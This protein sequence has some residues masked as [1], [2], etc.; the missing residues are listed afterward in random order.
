M[1]IIKIIILILIFNVSAFC[2]WLENIPQKITQSDGRTIDCFASGDQF[3]HRLHDRDDYTIILNELNGDFYYAKK[4]NGELVPS[5]F[6]VGDIDPRTT[7]LVP[8]AMISKENYAINKD[9][10]EQ[11][12]SHRNNRDAPTSGLVN[13][14]NVFIRFADDPPFP[15]TRAY[16][17]E[18]FNAVDQPS[19]R[20]Y[21]FEVSYGA[22]TVDTYHYP[23]TMFGENNSYVDPY[24]RGYYSPNSST[25]PQGY[26]ND[27]ERTQREHSLLA[28]A[29]EA[30]QNSV[31]D[32]LD[33]DLDND[34]YV[35]AVSFSVYGNVD[36]WADLLWPHRWS[37]YTETAYIN[38]SQV[39]D[40][41]FELTESSY[42]TVGVLCHEFFHVLGA[43]DLYHYDGGNAPDAVG[44]WD[45]MESTSNPPQYMGAYMKWKYGD[46]FTS[47]PEITASGTYTLNPL[48]QPDNAVYKVASPNS[49]TEYFVLEYRVK[50]GIYESNTPGIRDG[51]LVYRINTEAGNGNAQGPPDEVYLYRPS[52]NLTQNG[53]F[54]EAPYSSN[55]NH[56][57]IND[58]TNPEPF[59]YNNGSGAPGGLNILNVGELGESITF[60]VSMGV[61]S[62]SLSPESISFEMAPDAFS[63]Q[64]VILTND[65]DAATTLMFDIIS[66]SLPFQNPSGGP[67]GGG[68]FWSSSD[69]EANLDYNWVDIEGIGTLV[70]FANNDNSPGSVDIGFNFPFFDSEY[71]QCLINPNGWIGFGSSVPND[72]DY[73]NDDLPNTGS[74]R[75][76]IMG[77]WDDLNPS[78]S[79]GNTSASGDVY[80]YRDP[81]NNY[82]VIWYDHVVRYQ[83][84]V[85][86]NYGE[87]DFQIVLYQDG[88]F[89]INYREMIG[90]VSSATIGFQNAS[91]S[92]GTTIAH[93]QN[94]IQSNQSIFTA[95]AST[96]S[97][98]TFGTPTGEMGGLI[99]GGQSFDISVMANTNGLSVGSYNATLTVLSDQ[100]PPESVPISLSVSGESTTLSLPFI[101]ISNSENGIVP[102]PVF[103]S[104]FFTDVADYY[105]HII[106]PNGESIPIIAQSGVTDSQ[107]IHV[108]NVLENYLTDIP[109]SAMGSNKSPVLNALS[110]SNAVLFV[111]N[112]PSES[113]SDE[114]VSLSEAG[115]IGQTVFA[116]EIFPEGVSEY[117]ASESR[118]ATYSAVLRYVHKYGIKNALPSMQSSVV[119]LMNDAINNN[120]FIP[121]SDL[122]EEQ[123]DQ[124]YLSLLLET[125]FGIWGHDPNNDQWAGEH[126]YGYINRESMS[127]GD[128][129][130]YNLI[131]GFFGENWSYTVALPVD[132]N[133]LFSMKHDPEMPYTNRSKYLKNIKI[134]GVNN[135]DIIGNMNQNRVLGNQG[136]NIFEGGGSSDF[137]DGGQGIDRAVFSGDQGEYALLFPAEWNDYKLIIVDF[138]DSRDGA[139]TLLNVEELDFNGTLY[140]SDG[141]LL[142]VE[143]N[144]NLPSR[145]ALFPNF[146]N[147]F[148]PETVIKFALPRHSSVSLN[149]VNVLGKTV[150]LLKN[151]NMNSGYHQ[152]KWDGLDDS[153]QLVSAGIYFINLKSE[154]YFSSRKILLLK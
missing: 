48:Q 36:G 68:Y 50:E 32:D 100:V 51:L 154:D 98:L 96:P 119:S 5:V 117:M 46:W 65:G 89:D 75:P 27:D 38:G 13:Q 122:L 77:M 19:L 64:S 78:N 72:N 152:V 2:H 141:N 11:H 146:P 34:G 120:K 82:F 112:D 110:L 124:R 25:N 53:T 74:P 105:T 16:Y 43:P 102:L 138:Y 94:F 87:F 93:N 92:E 52:G 62:I 10:Y 33:I 26:S 85:N 20:D 30:I 101:D 125:F 1:Q 57:V 14:I 24:N 47:I 54:S 104:S 23:P 145:Y 17:D 128:L 76:A 86:P 91:G 153:G 149:I 151:Q 15:N 142:D 66:A 143:K 63:T 150:R 107:L 137:F 97:W 6:K 56:T 114:F 4:N 95:K 81:S 67:D 3:S 55:W 84:T 115:A 80:Y 31:P 18:P 44:G 139:D 109:E 106:A 129:Q 9:H 83:G 113:E 127:A 29:I 134:S 70:Q 108:R 132:F 71:G 41:S 130:A 126:E 22:L 37:L 7:D 118:D 69:S 147:P 8:G 49:E 12:M 28:N 79:N 135:I 60:T 133:G 40:Y 45:V 35:D 111:L 61:P 123:Y 131:K 140:S 116:S 39:A 90:D 59:L 103:V 88:H 136:V 42:F 99:P 121:A 144:N 58:F 21:F 148:N 73:S